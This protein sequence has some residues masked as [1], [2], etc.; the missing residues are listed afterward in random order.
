LNGSGEPFFV[1]MA[2]SALMPPVSAFGVEGALQYSIH[3]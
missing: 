1:R 2:A 3:W